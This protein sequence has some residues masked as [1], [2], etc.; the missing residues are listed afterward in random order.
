ML[1]QF[2]IF[3]VPY[4]IMGLAALSLVFFIIRGWF[5]RWPVLIIGSLALTYVV[6][7]W[8]QLFIDCSG[9]CGAHNDLIASGA[10]IASIMTFACI[11]VATSIMGRPQRYMG[12]A[13]RLLRKFRERRG[14]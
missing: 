3:A 6:V 13:M 10:S 7:V 4:W 8:W 5:G 12:E 14:G 9:R 1:F 11:A 2:F